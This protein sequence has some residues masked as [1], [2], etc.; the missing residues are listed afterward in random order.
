MSGSFDAAAEAAGLPSASEVATPS[1]ASL[2]ALRGRRLVGLLSAASAG[3][4]FSIPAPFAHLGL[5]FIPTGGVKPEATGEWPSPPRVAAVG[6]TW[7]ATA[8][9]VRDG[10]QI[11]RAAMARAKELR[12]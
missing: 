6:S 2:A 8:R 5:R 1:D 3:G 9:D 10:D 7:I 12:P 4:P 11:A